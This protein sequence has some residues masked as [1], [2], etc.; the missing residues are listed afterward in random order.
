MGHSRFVWL[1]RGGIVGLTT[2]LG[3]LSVGCGDFET[4]RKTPE[5]G[6]LGREMYTMI[7]DRVG[8]QALRE[9]ITGASYHAV[10]H[11]DE[12][13]AFADEVDREKLPELAPADDEEGNPVSVEQQ[14]KNRSYRIARIEALARRRDDLIGAFDVAFADEKIPVKRLDAEDETESCQTAK[15]KGRELRAELADM[16]GRLTDLYNDDTIPHLTRSLSRVMQGVERSP[17]AQKALARFD[18]RRGYRPPDTAAGGALPLLSYPRLGELA[19]AVLR[20]LSN[21]S[22]PLGLRPGATH[23]RAAERTARDR[24]PGAGNAALVNLLAAARE[25]LRTA[26]TI[27]TPP[28]LVA[29]PDERDPFFLR[30]SRPRGNLEF[31]RSILFAQD[32]AFESSTPRYVVLRDVRGVAKVALED[33]K[34]PTPFVDKT[35]DGLADVDEL[36][37]FVT[38]GEPAPYPFRD[39]TG[40]FA[41][42]RDSIGRAIRGRSAAYDYLDV[43][44]TFLSAFRRDLV[45]LLDPDVDRHHETIMDLLAGLYVVAGTREIEPMSSRTYDGDVTVRYRAFRNDSSPL[46]DL[47]HAFGQVLADP[48]S[49]DTLALLQRLLQ[50]QPQVVA[51]LAGVGFRIKEIADRHP[52]ASIPAKSTFWDEILDVAAKMSDRPALIEDVLRA[53]GDDATVNLAAAGAIYMTTRDELTYDR[54]DING[55]P[56]NLTTGSKQTLVTPVDRGQAD[57]GPNRSAFQ[58]FLQALHDTNGMSTCTKPGAVAHIVW[59]GLPLDYPSFASVA[60]VAL[61][62]PPPQNPSPMCGLFRVKNIAEEVVNAVL[63]EVQLDIRDE[64]LRRIVESPLTGIVGGADAFLEDVS[65]IR[66]FNTKPSVQGINR[67]VYFDLPYGG[68]TGDTVNV[69]A[70]N[71]FRDLFDP[72]PTLACPQV[73]FT[74]VDGAQLNLRQCSRFEDG[75]RGRD[76]NA[77]FPLE[78]LGFIEASKPLARAFKKSDANLLFVELFDVLHRHW[79]SPKQSKDECDPSLPRTNARWC[80]QD[81]AVSYEPLL[82][83]ALR[84]DLFSV[85]NQS[86]KVLATIRV[87]HCD[88]RDP[89]SGACTAASEIDGVKV[90]AEAIRA[91]VSP[92]ANRGLKNRQGEPFGYR[93]DG[94]KTEQVTPIYLLID[95]L[96]GF[97]ARFAEHAE[98]VPGDDRLTQWRRAR[99]QLVDQLFAVDGAGTFSHFRNPA[100]EKILPVVVSSLRSQLLANCP[101][102]S[103][104]CAWARAELPAKVRETVTGPTFAGVMDVLDAIRRDP[105]ARSELERLLTHLLESTENDAEGTTLTA[106]ADLLQIFE[107]DANLTALLHAGADAAAPEVVSADG[108][109]AE[110]GLVLAGVEVLWRILGEARDGDGNRL[111]SREIDPNRTLSF[112][113]ER[114]LEPSPELAS[115]G[116]P[117]RAPLDVLID[118]VADVNRRD[119]EQTE[120]LVADDYAS[121]AFQVGDFCAHKERGLEQ[122]Y[123]VIKHATKDL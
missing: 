48:T 34:I 61:L 82:A 115:S 31:A 60:C 87:P 17:E 119:P 76:A 51:Q 42:S 89:R 21:D 112:V 5:R 80:S 4:D 118:V 65:G 30:L 103:A 101:N 32:P 24:V 2:I 97:D 18:A 55:S 39:P 105:A 20:V 91:M 64:C 41:A 66:G 72:T 122:V 74:D 84:T 57:T 63:G 59:N 12:K 102:L 85:L 44:T 117:P 121:I 10:C 120:K 79:G 78:E 26:E 108:R 3:V 46:L 62:A 81:G 68:H 123:A 8:A 107:D 14:R 90:L 9:D 111:C 99:S 47:V 96:K 86:V 73:P 37:R 58:R 25:E 83:E 43:N 56:F 19:S 114:L 49:D 88:A 92:N 110:R 27:P 52:E 11:A 75:L 23:K 22:D 54:N 35:G 53:F 94:I 13:G 40:D 104:S 106:L 67:M 69:K 77:L 98:E 71:F 36:G 100:I 15:G 33:G 50:D 28:P 38:A 93:S 116:L 45:P 6:S 109:V 113:L 70:R 7:C 1:R 16:L 95:A 29:A